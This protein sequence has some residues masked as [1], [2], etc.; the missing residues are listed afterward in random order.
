MAWNQDEWDWLSQMTGQQMTADKLRGGWN[1]DF[2]Q[3]S[4]DESGNYANSWNITPENSKYWQ[5]YFNSGDDNGAQALGLSTPDE[6]RLVDPTTGRPIHVIQEDTWANSLGNIK[7]ESQVKYDPYLGAYTDKANMD[8]QKRGMRKFMDTVG[9]PALIAGGALA[10]AWPAISQMMAAGATPA[11]AAAATGV[12][13]AEVVSAAAAGGPSGA[14]AGGSFVPSAAT[15]GMLGVNSAALAGTSIPPA[16]SAELSAAMSAG[17]L[18]AAEVG[19]LLTIPAVSNMAAGGSS[20]ASILKDPLAQT[21]IK[22]IAPQLI[23]SALG[24]GS[25][26]SGGGGGNMGDAAAADER[27]WQRQLEA[28]NINRGWNKEDFATNQAAID[29]QTHQN[30]PN[31]QSDFGSVTWSADAN[32]NPVQTTSLDPAHQ[33][34]LGA[35]RGGQSNAINQIQG[36]TDPTRKGNWTGQAEGSRMGD[37]TGGQSGFDVNSDVMNAYRGINQPLVDQQRDRENARLAAM[38]LSTGSGQAW[39]QA[40]DALNRNQVNADQNAIMKGFDATMQTRSSDRANA[41]LN[42]QM[43]RGDQAS[44]RADNAEN[45]ADYGAALAGQGQTLQNLNALNQTE[46]GW[47]ANAA[48]QSPFASAGVAQIG[49][50]PFNAPNTDYQ[51]E[52][53]MWNT[54]QQAAQ[55][56]QNQQGWQNAATA[57]GGKVF[58]KIFA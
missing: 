45:R 29:R 30:R 49:T 23:S 58:D 54:Q 56:A 17:S 53:N 57:I 24:S 44:S 40:Q 43:Y 33:A 13:E 5:G 2:S 9:V 26:G 36:F 32:G 7:D 19:Q 38:G 27:N 25:G 35:L 31:Q 51:G 10:I 6:Y 47:N 12:P 21:A 8:T 52:M 14:A 37:W 34:M 48:A 39:G 46:T 41:T 16:L 11:Q 42:E 22:A 28:A 1:N 4:Q 18:T 50:S 55:K 3:G 20:L 15:N